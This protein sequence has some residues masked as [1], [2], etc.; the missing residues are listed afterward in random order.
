MRVTIVPSASPGMPQLFTSFVVDDTVAIDAGCLDRVGDLDSMGRIKH[1][2]LT[3]SHLDHLASLPPFLDAVY[4]GSGDCVVVHGNAHVLDCLRRDIFNNR[5]F[6]DF[7]QI[8]TFRPPYLQLHEL[9]AG[10]AVEVGA[11]RITPI[12]VNHV[13]PA[14]GYIVEDPFAAVVLPGDTGPTE[15]IWR[16]AERLPTLRAVFLECTFP[17]SMEWLAEIAR[18]LTPQR[19][20]SEMQKLPRRVRFI[21]VHVQARHRNTVLAELAALQLPGVEIGEAG[22]TYQF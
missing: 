12:E 20:A 3:H 7:V 18:H 16:I 19:F 22:E 15:E 13:V 5:L 10:Q 8:S 17:N 6:P 2:F 14:L 1:V 21:T 4:D 9:T 11:L